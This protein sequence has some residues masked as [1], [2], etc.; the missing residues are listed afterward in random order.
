[1]NKQILKKF[2]IGEFSYFRIMRSLFFIYACLCIYAYFFTD[3]II[4][5][6]QPSTYQDNDRI[7][8]LTTKD[9][10]KIS[11]VYLPNPQA[12][13]TILYSHGNAE[14]LGEIQFVLEELRNL[15]F[16]VFSYD[17][18]GY[19]TSQGKPT[20]TTTYKDIDAAY[21]Y[22]TQKLGVNPENII[23]YGRSVGG[24]P[25]VDLASRKLVGGLILENTFVST[26]RVATQIPIVPFDKFNNIAKIQKVRSPILIMYGKADRVIPFWHGEKLFATANEPKQVLVIENGGHDDFREV[27][28]KKYDRA[29]QEFTQLIS[30]KGTGD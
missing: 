11:A 12:K 9:G 4:F 29:L 19:G 21:N 15:G 23:L 22:L 3:R 16:A 20:E 5:L 13:F 7:L 6:P 1:M 27:A 10:A 2:I 28:G 14:D 17:Y 24:G 25:S 26:F 30:Q 8:K 18:R